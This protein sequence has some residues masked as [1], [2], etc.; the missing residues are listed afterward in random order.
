[1][2][3]RKRKKQQNNIVNTGRAKGRVAGGWA[4]L[5]NSYCT[6]ETFSSETHSKYKLSES[7]LFPKI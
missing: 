1:M 7:L 2:C 6:S 5:H 4:R 3:V